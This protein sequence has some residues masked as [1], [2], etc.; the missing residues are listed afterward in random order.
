MEAQQGRVTVNCQH[1]K[2]GDQP[3]PLEHHDII[4]LGFAF[5]MRLIVPTA[6]ESMVVTVTDE[7][8]IIK[9]LGYE[10]SQEGMDCAM[11]IKECCD[12]LPVSLRAVF[13]NDLTEAAHLIDEANFI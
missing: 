5:R 9:L 13:Y 12:R 6:S 4:C 8:E 2:S 3:C 11:A 10:H 7:S 1:L